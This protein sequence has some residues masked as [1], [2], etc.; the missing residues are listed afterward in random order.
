MTLTTVNHAS[1]WHRVVLSILMAWL[2]LAVPVQAQDGAQL[3]LPRVQLSA[4]MHLMDVQ[5]RCAL[6]ASARS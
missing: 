4:G 6:C 1:R 2:A 3:D 5:V